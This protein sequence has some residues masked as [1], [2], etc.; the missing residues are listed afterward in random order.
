MTNSISPLLQRPIAAIMGIINVTP[1]SFSDG[2]LH[3]SVDAAV[4]HAR[5]LV[6]Q[7]ADILDVGGES[8]RPGAEPVELQQELDR[9]IPVVER[10]RAETD[11]AISIDTVKPAVMSAAIEAGANMVNDV[12]GMR[13][14]AAIAAIATHDVTVC[15]MHMQGAPQNMQSAPHYADVVAEVTGF[16][17]AR[18][19]ACRKAGMP[20]EH[21]V[22][23]PGIGFGKSLEHNLSLLNAVPTFRESIGC[24]ILIG[25]SRKSMIDHLL[26]RDVEHRLPASIGLAVQ[27]A[28]NGAKIL[29]VHDVRATY[30]AIRAVE[31]V[32]NA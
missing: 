19:A 27:A 12:N 18:I 6:A 20:K 3:L 14:D 29:R 5:S 8:T 22:I 30:D 28:L 25:V 23:D 32:V 24:E 9:V 16:L 31:A 15:I 1:D 21:I 7:G 11:I 10:I 17:K 2:G 13:S 4:E 26:V